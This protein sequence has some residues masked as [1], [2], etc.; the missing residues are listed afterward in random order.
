[1]SKAKFPMVVKRGHTI[2]KIYCTP[3]HGCDSF[4]VVHYI[5]QKRHRKSFARLELAV[6]EAETVAN[7]LSTGELDVLTL[8]SDDRL[9]YVRTIQILKPTGVPLELAAMEFAQAHALL[10][11]G[12]EAQGGHG[13]PS[14]L[15]AVRYYVKMNPVNRPRKSVPELA[16]ELVES[17]EADR[18]SDVYVQD[19]RL[20]LKRFGEKHPGPIGQVT[21]GEIEDFLRGLKGKDGKALTGRSRNNYRRA[22]ATLF[23]YAETRGFLAKGQVQ[24]DSVALAKEENGDI[25]IFTPAELERLLGCAGEDLAPF[26]AIGAFAGLRHAEI[27][28]LDWAEVRLD[29]GFIEVK[30]S[31]AKTASRRLVPIVPNL[32]MWLEQYRKPSGKV[33]EYA[34]VTK[35]LLWLAEDVNKQGLA[36]EPPT[37]FVWKHNALRHSFVSYRLAQVQSAA[38]VALEAGNSPRMV[39]ANYRELVRPADAEK[40]FAITPESIKAAREKAEKERQ[41]KIVPHP[42]LAAA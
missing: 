3:S 13:G 37:G 16:K 25:E 4:T 23:Y 8:T 31:K 36:Q 33:C 15:E 19:L 20:R 18:M 7:K 34:N 1:M 35:Q 11:S 21:S 29:D 12:L 2:V 6:T 27:K 5:G 17:K 38:Q 26:I 40:W 28:R 41:A 30:A 39:F 9:A 22:I 32:K 14:L 42:A 10:N 24:V